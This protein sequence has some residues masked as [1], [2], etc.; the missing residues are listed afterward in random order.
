[1][2]YPVVLLIFMLRPS[3][4]AAFRAARLERGD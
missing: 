3:F 4:T 2:A 1:M